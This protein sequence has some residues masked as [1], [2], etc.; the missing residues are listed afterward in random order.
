[1]CTLLSKKFQPRR[2]RTNANEKGI[3]YMSREKIR[4]NLP[5]VNATVIQG[6]IKEDRA[7]SGVWEQELGPGQTQIHLGRTGHPRRKVQRRE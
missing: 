1:M 6:E 2:H 5:P 4:K 3:I 7:S